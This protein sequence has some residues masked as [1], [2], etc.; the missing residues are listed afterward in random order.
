[1]R[2]FSFG[3][4]FTVAFPNGFHVAGFHVARNDSGHPYLICYNNSI[5]PRNNS[6]PVL[7]PGDRFSCEG[8]P[9]KVDDDSFALSVGEVTGKERSVIIPA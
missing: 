5:H 2:D 8:V 1:M 9:F 3:Q 4:T 7:V 6:R